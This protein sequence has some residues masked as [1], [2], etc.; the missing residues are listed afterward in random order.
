M[1]R[2]FLIELSVFFSNYFNLTECKTEF[3]ILDT[4]SGVNFKENMI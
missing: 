2:T 3:E 4:F 1:C